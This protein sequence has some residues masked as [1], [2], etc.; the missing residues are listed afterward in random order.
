MLPSVMGRLARQSGASS[1]HSTPRPRRTGTGFGRR[2]C[3]SAC[4][5]FRLT[6]RNLE[7][8]CRRLLAGRAVGLLLLGHGGPGEHLSPCGRLRF[9]GAVLALRLRA[10]LGGSGRVRFYRRWAGFELAS[11]W[12]PGVV[13]GGL[14]RPAGLYR[15]VVLPMLRLG[16][17]AVRAPSGAA[18]SLRAPPQSCGPDRHHSGEVRRSDSSAGNDKAPAACRN[19]TKVAE[20]A[21][22]ACWRKVNPTRTDQTRLLLSRS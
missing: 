21:R 12:R 4:R 15:P 13:S 17:A 18:L 19:R 22:A 10:G 9:Y 16:S 3:S 20:R 5:G 14:C 1:G 11:P 6:L 8:W 7:R 2:A